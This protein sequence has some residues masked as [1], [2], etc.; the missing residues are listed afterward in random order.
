MKM[1][2]DERYNADLQV[3]L[4]LDQQIDGELLTVAVSDAGDSWILTPK[5]R[6]E[7]IEMFHHPLAFKKVL[8]DA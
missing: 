4:Y 1:I 6:A 2:V 3:T 7:A 8:V 5:D